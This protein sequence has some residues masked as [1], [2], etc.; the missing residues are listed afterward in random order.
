MAAL[1]S[2]IESPNVNGWTADRT[3]AFQATDC[4]GRDHVNPD[5]KW[6]ALDAD[7]NITS[8]RR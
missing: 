2:K 3:E 4:H 8:L 7:G 5:A 1:A 6:V